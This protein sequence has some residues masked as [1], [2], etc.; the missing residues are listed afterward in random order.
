MLVFGWLMVLFGVFAMLWADG[1][2][3]KRDPL[4]GAPRAIRRTRTTSDT[5][6]KIIAVA[7]IGIL[8]RIGFFDLGQ[9]A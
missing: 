3:A 9:E 5:M 7:M 6:F 1:A 2:F 8:V 4:S